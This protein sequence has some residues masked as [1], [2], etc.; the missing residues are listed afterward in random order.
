ME[1]ESARAVA[2]VAL[3]RTTI[4]DLM[5]NR[6][7]RGMAA[8]FIGTFALVF[9]GAGSIVLTG[10][11][12]GGHGNLLTVGLAHAMALA[13]FVTGCMYISGSQFNPAV[14]LGLVIS[15]KQ[16]IDTALAFVVAQC[17]AAVFAA[18]L[19]LLF[20][21][22]AMAQAEGVNL[23]ATLGM[24]STGETQNLMGLIGLEV[25]ASFAL[26]LV[27]HTCAVDPRAHRTGGI[28]VGLVVL[29]CILAIGPVTGASMNPA[30]SFGPAV[31]GHWDVHWVYWVAP[32]AGGT[33][34]GLV[35]KTVFDAP[36]EPEGE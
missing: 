23:G 9:F 28:C 35:Y 30:R 19:I 2:P 13:V 12:T 27:V 20:F 1:R 34:A 5:Q 16:K 3:R 36:M 6:V 17:A 10:P 14:S 15:G 4:G 18:W 32:L 29:M 31:F 22:E 8:E 25:V 26:V 11:L 24:F 7:A 33:L 21:G